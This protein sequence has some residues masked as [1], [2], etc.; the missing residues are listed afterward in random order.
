MTRVRQGYYPEQIR[1]KNFRTT[2]ADLNDAQAQVYFVIKVYE[3]ITTEDIAKRLGKYPHTV[4]GRVKELR[5]LNYVEFAGE[6]K[7]NDS[8]RSASLWRV[9]PQ[10]PQIELFQ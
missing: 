6:K 2:Q 1:D 7:L 8:G 9:V 10:S 4:S 3:S 5:D